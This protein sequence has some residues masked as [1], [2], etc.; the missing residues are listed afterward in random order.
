MKFSRLTIIEP[1]SPSSRATYAPA[2]PPPRIRMPLRASR[3]STLHFYQPTAEEGALDV[4]RCERESV[5]V[6]G[7]RLAF[8]VEPPQQ[9]GARRVQE[10]VVVEPFDCVG[11]REALLGSVRERNRDGEIE[12]D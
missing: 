6:R 10:V 1:R 4:A 8:A 5:L 2:K 9:V 7:R 12:V 3:S 11:D